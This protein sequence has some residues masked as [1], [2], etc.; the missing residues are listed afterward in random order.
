[1]SY[2]FT[3]NTINL[4]KTFECGQC[5]RFEQVEEN[6]F[7]GVAFSK[8]LRV[9]QNNNIITLENADQKDFIDIWKSFFDLDTDYNKITAKLTENDKIMKQAAEFG[10]GIH[11]LRQELF[12]TI[13]S[14]IIS[15]NNNIPR[16]KKII[17]LLCENFGTK[18]TENK[19][20]YYAFPT[21]EQLK[22]LTVENLSVIRAGFRAKYIVDA[23]EKISNNSVKTE[24]IKRISYEEAKAELMNIKGIG[25][26]VADCVL[27]FGASK[28]G[29]FP[30]DVWIKR[31]MK[32][33]YHDENA[34]IQGEYAGIAQQYLFYFARETGIE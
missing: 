3:D 27:L 32:S 28:F 5:F 18:I 24:N 1:M 6:T 34:V 26:K 29:A 19:K 13:I 12:E 8:F 30:K 33:L 17:N 11:I 14:F 31:I 9:S 10:K 22:G 25:N 20:T 15:Q 2:S 23:V 7:E 4:K 21:L 16:I